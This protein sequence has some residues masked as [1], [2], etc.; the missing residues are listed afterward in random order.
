MVL[1]VNKVAYC[2]AH[3]DGSTHVFEGKGRVARITF[4]GVELGYLFA[5]H[6][7]QGASGDMHQ[8]GYG[9]LVVQLRALK[10]LARNRANMWHR[11]L[12]VSYSKGKTEK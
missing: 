10:L 4:E 11:E 12:C 2:M 7:T 1:Q 6:P 9:V 3:D 8:Q 5:Y